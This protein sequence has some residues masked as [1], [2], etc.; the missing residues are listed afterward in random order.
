MDPRLRLCHLRCFLETARLG[1]LSA[2]AEVLCVSQ[3]AAS[4]TLRELEEILGVQLFDRSTRRLLLSPAGRVFQQHA[5]T[6]MRALE[7][8][9]E[10]V[11]DAPER[12]TRL[13]L[14]VLPTVATDLLP[15]AALKYNQDVP[16]CI[17]QLTTGPNWLLLSQLREGAL[18]L[19]VGRMPDAEHMN[20]LTFRQLYP[21]RVVIVVRPGHPLLN[22][23]D[24]PAAL[25]KYKL[26]LP[27]AG[28]LIAPAVRGWLVSVGL[29]HMEP[30]FETVSL[31]F[32]RKLVINSDIVWFISEGVVADELASGVLTTLNPESELP[33]GPVGICQ[34]A[35]SELTHETEAFVKLLREMCDTIRNG[36]PSAAFSQNA[37]QEKRQ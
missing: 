13:N 2:A 4:K 3:P 30:T 17:L 35:N 36:Q 31:A 16:H 21:E 33:T 12:I 6:A 25:A 32:G 11:Q 9:Q 15:R 18:D 24:F 14:G 7:A 26:M 29:S 8:A 37:D 34:R 20:G 10:A 22:A 28:A 19:M 23:S 5:G 27:P 1:G